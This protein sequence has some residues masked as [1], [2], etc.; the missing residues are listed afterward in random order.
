MAVCLP[1]D[2]SPSAL[3]D[4]ANISS[5]SFPSGSYREFSSTDT[6]IFGFP[7]DQDKM[8]SV[9][10]W[11]YVREPQIDFSNADILCEEVFSQGP[12]MGRIFFHLFLLGLYWIFDTDMSKV[13]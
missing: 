1:P 2:D 5:S 8:G 10:K 13:Y 7:T 9:L 3:V 6:L 4:I 12:H 11:F